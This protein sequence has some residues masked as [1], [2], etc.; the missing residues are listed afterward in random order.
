MILK[1]FITGVDLGEAFKIADNM[2]RSVFFPAVV[3]KVS[4]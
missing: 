3:L 2:R 1:F 4:S